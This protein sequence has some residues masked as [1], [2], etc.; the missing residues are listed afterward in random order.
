MNGTKRGASEGRV[1]GEVHEAAIATPARR[2][3]SIAIEPDK[4]GD[5][6]GVAGAKGVFAR[7]GHRV[8]ATWLARP[9]RWSVRKDGKEGR[10]KEAT[11]GGCGKQGDRRLC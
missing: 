10:G 4:G 3:R 5:F 9:R 8:R 7:D 2:K 6:A 11:G 1:C